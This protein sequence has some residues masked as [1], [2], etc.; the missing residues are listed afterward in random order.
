MFI[1]EVYIWNRYIKVDRKSS[2]WIAK[3]TF[4]FGK[5]L[6]DLIPAIYE[7]TE[8]AEIYF[9]NM[10][11]MKLLLQRTARASIYS[12]INMAFGRVHLLYLQRFLYFMLCFAILLYEVFLQCEAMDMAG[13]TFIQVRIDNKL[14]QEATDIL[15]EIGM[16][17]PNAVRMF[18]KR[19]VIERG[20]PFD[21]KLPVSKH[22][23]TTDKPIVIHIPAHPTKSIPMQEYIDLL[24]K[25]PEGKITR[26]IDIE[27]YLEKKYNV[28]HVQIEFAVNFANPLW[29]GIPLWREVSTR[30]M[31]QDNRHCSR[32]RQA[33]MLRKEGHNIVPCG[34]YQRSL[35]VNNYKDFLFDF[36]SLDEDNK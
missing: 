16:D 15:S 33:E 1:Y 12:V 3:L 6:Q 22:E 19:V 17:M 14:K 21:T 34:S 9:T 2:W 18:L 28:P 10:T 27:G 31:L 4:G 26:L 7:S 30:G 25:V 24:C 32:D 8:Q 13:Q 23:P 20:L 11:N 5:V 35:K 36:D 29:G